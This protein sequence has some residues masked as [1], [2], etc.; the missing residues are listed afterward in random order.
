RVSAP[1]AWWWL[2]GSWPLLPPGSAPVDRPRGLSLESTP[3]PGAPVTAKLPGGGGED[4]RIDELGRPERYD[5]RA[6]ES[7]RPC[8]SW[9]ECGWLPGDIDRSPNGEVGW[10]GRRSRPLAESPPEE[11]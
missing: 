6:A 7:G 11:I 1:P 2:H 9:W 5:G 4:K 8:T 10:S 3:S